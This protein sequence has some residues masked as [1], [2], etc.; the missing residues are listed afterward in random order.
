M[1]IAPIKI[2][3]I[4]YHNINKV[5]EWVGVYALTSKVIYLKLQYTHI[6][7]SIRSLFDEHIR[8]LSICIQVE[9]IDDTYLVVSGLPKRNEGRHI[10]H[11]ANMALTLLRNVS[12]LPVRHCPG[13][14]LMLRIGIH[15]GPCAA[16]ENIVF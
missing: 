1:V 14:H 7:G 16:G 5:N 10:V 9:T 11:I 4:G 13:L 3:V 12:R 2:Y 6:P 8:K 15:T